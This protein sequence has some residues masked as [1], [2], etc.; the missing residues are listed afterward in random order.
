MPDFRLVP[1]IARILA[2]DGF[3]TIVVLTEKVRR[4]AKQTVPAETVRSAVARA[5]RAGL[6]ERTVAGDY[7]LAPAPKQI[8]GILRRAPWP[9]SLNA[10]A[11]AVGWRGQLFELDDL[12]R[13]LLENG[14]VKSPG[15]GHTHWRE[16]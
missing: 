5:I 13:E 16:A 7:A 8:V 4:R 12:L 3:A 9:M 6:I 2:V 11:K 15:Y 1:L 10:L 14:L